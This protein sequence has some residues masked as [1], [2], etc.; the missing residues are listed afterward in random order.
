MAESPS[1]GGVQRRLKSLSPVQPI[2]RYFTWAGLLGLTKTN[3]RFL[4]LES[5]RSTTNADVVLLCVL[6]LVV[7]FRWRLTVP[8]SAFL[9]VVVSAGRACSALC[10]YAV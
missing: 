7:G 5:S 10:V 3:N 6:L 4:T 9:D 2:G 8:N 1:S